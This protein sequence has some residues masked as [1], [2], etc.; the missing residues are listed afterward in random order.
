MRYY[1]MSGFPYTIV[2]QPRA[3]DV[4]EI[5]AVAHHRRYVKYWEPRR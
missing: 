4:V 5:V 2:Y 1:V 3:E